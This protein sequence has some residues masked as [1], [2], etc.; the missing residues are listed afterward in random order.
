MTRTTPARPVDVVGLF[1]ELARHARTSTRLHPRSGSPTVADSSVGGP[2][3]W[4][5]DEPWPTCVG[6]H[7][8]YGLARPD[9]ERRLR[10]LVAGAVGRPYTAGESAEVRRIH[11][12]SHVLDDRPVPLLP[13]AQFHARDLPDLFCPDDTDLLQ[14]LWCPLNHPD[15]ELPAV[16]LRWRRAATVTDALTSPP[17]PRL[18]M[19][20]YLPNPC[21]L[22]PEQVTEYP[23]HEA[24]PA[25]LADR[26][27]A[28]DD[29][30]NLYQFDL[31][32]APGWKVGGWPAPWTFRDPFPTDCPCGSPAEALL[33]IDSYEWDG[34]NRSWR[35]VEDEHAPPRSSE[36]TGVCIA[37]GYT[38]QVY[39]CRRDHTHP[40]VSMMQ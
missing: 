30:R 2:L 23:P 24:L 32:V 36:P 12:L 11:A 13:V 5:A 26:V 19:D 15:E 27:E 20:D 25:D 34:G 1:P 4:P 31:S 22:H 10:S 38:L 21:V 37:R 29:G 14:V 8:G 6:P 16:R 40:P 9:D 3:L 17:E 35:P 18:V 7:E 33:T 39:R 28:W